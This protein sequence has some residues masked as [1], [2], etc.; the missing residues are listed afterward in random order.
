MWNSQRKKPLKKEVHHGSSTFVL[1]QKIPK[2]FAQNKA[3]F[4]WGTTVWSGMWETLGQ[5]WLC[6]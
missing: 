4:S 1:L 3:S 6:K 2:F 5:P